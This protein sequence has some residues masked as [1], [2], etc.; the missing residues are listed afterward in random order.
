MT[1]CVM[2][3][4]EHLRSLPESN[5]MQH[6]MLQIESTCGLSTHSIEYPNLVCNPFRGLGQGPDVKGAAS[7]IKN[8]VD[9]AT[10]DLGNPLKGGLQLPD[11]GNPLKGGLPGSNVDTSISTKPI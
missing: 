5:A 9:Q 3:A 10:P 2:P 11:L 6:G 1:A 7:D 4:H 8:K